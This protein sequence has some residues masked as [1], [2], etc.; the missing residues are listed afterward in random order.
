[1]RVSKHVIYF[2]S[3]FHESSILPSDHSRMSLL[4]SRPYTS[5][6]GQ[7]VQV[8][9]L[10]ALLHPSI[11]ASSRAGPLSH[12]PRTLTYVHIPRLEVRTYVQSACRSRCLQSLKDPRFP[13]FPITSRIVQRSMTIMSPNDRD[14]LPKEYDYLTLCPV[15]TKI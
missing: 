15:I 1:M 8:K 4:I 14:V 7:T 2:T 12:Y 9:T 3:L 6:L 5:L 11:V 13:L 10:N